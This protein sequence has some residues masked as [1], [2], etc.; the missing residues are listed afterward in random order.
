MDLSTRPQPLSRLIHCGDGAQFL[1]LDL[2]AEVPKQWFLE[3]VRNRHALERRC[4]DTMVHSQ[5]FPFLQSLPE[6]RTVHIRAV[7]SVSALGDTATEQDTILLA[8]E[9][10]TCVRHIASHQS[11]LETVMVA[12]TP[13]VRPTPFDSFDRYEAGVPHDWFKAVLLY[14]VNIK[15]YR[16]A[17]P[18]VT[19]RNGTQSDRRRFMK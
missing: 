14:R 2:Q 6:I 1:K 11:T 9:L 4:S 16:N 13:C 8:H 19:C 10:A 5:L 7:A 18:V 3:V 17:G 15:R 12:F